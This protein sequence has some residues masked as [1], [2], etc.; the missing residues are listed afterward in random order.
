[1]AKIELGVVWLLSFA[2]L[3]T[4]DNFTFVLSTGASITIIL[5]N[6]P[7]ACKVIKSI[8]SKKK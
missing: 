7:T 4:K 8:T 1:M 2:A 3:I 5:R 6:L